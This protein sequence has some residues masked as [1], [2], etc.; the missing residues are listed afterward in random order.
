MRLEDIFPV[1][2]KNRKVLEYAAFAGGRVQ[3]E[4]GRMSMRKEEV[5]QVMES[6]GSEQD[7]TQRQALAIPGEMARGMFFQATLDAVRTL[8]DEEAV[9]CCLEASGEEKF[10]DFFNYPVGANIRLLFTAARLLRERCGG[11]EEALRQLGLRSGAQFMGSAAGK[12]LLLLARGE[13]GRLVGHLPS[14]YRAAVSYGERSVVWTGPTSGRILMRREFM[15]YPF[16]EGLLAGVL[17]VGKVREARVLG[18]QLSTLDSEY[19]ISWVE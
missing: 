12:A 8:G 1:S 13:P 16:H 17:E 6:I 7:V 4:G 11:L 14:V 9:R 18:R 2:L 19:D 3:S 10:V 15:P 5:R